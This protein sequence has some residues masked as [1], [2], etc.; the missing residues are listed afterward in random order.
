MRSQIR[1]LAAMI[2]ATTL[3]WGAPQGP[4]SKP[5]PAASRA[6]LEKTV[7]DYV[8]LYARPSLEQ[9]KALFHP[10]LTVTYPME[11]GG[12]RVRNLEEF[13][14]AQKRYFETGRSIQERLANVR[15]EEGWRIARVTADFVFVDEGKE[16]RGKLG[17]HLVQS[18]EGWRIVGI[19]FSYDQ[20]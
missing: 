14:G 7:S 5:E 10:S 11:D 3:L 17:L 9:W 1:T 15:I 18:K 20:P 12:T 16:S 4:E 6:A 8:G 19:I 2:F 13:Y